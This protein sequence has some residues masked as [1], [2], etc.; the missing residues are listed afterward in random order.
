MKIISSSPDT[1]A[2][3]VYAINLRRSTLHISK[4]N[5]VLQSI[6]NIGRE[7]PLGLEMSSTEGAVQKVM[8]V[9]WTSLLVTDQLCADFSYVRMSSIVHILPGVSYEQRKD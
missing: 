6:K 7:Y 8:E 3:P 5:P 4:T 1:Q 9:Y 2:A